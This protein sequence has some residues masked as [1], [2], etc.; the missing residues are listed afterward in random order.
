[1]AEGYYE[2]GKFYRRKYMAGSTHYTIS[3]CGDADAHVGWFI[4]F[5]SS[6]PEQHL[7]GEMEEASANELDVEERQT[8]VAKFFET[9]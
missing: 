5:F 1:M 8:I 7:W 2:P 9:W 4:G 6:S 3:L